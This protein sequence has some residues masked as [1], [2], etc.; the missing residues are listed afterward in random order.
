MK[1]KESGIQIERERKRYG[2]KETK[3]ESERDTVVSIGRLTAFYVIISQPCPPKNVDI[4]GFVNLS[5]KSGSYAKV[6]QIKL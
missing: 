5:P 4:Y 6:Q 1:E 2:N 3:R